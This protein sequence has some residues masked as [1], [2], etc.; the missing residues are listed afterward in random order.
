MRHLFRICFL[1]SCCFANAHTGFTQTQSQFDT[2]LN[3]FQGD[4]TQPQIAQDTTPP[5]TSLS[6][7]LLNIF[8]QPI[9]K[10]YRISAIQVTGNNYFDQNL[11]LSIAGL[12]VGDEVVL[13]GGDNFSKAITKLWSQNYF[14]DVSIY[15]T[16]VK[17]DAITVEVNVTERPRLSRFEFKGVKKSE[18]D[19]LSPKTGLVVNRV[20][21]ENLKRTSSDAIKKFYADKGYR[22]VQVSI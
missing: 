8:N 6:P 21:T 20:I 1:V 2:T 5:V 15:L 11:L 4:S 17:D 13:P 18:V 10:K 16:S 7:D 9:P 22:N 12:S 14:S 19:D 3:P